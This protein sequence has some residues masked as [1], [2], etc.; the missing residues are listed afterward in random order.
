MKPFIL[1]AIM[2]SGVF[3][4]SPP[5]APVQLFDYTHPEHEVQ[6]EYIR[7][8]SMY[9]FKKSNWELNFDDD[10]CP[11]TSVLICPRGKTCE[12]PVDPPGPPNQCDLPSHLVDDDC[13]P[14]GDCHTQGN[15]P[16]PICEV[17]IHL[18]IIQDGVEI[19]EPDFCKI[20]ENKQDPKCK[21]VD[22]CDLL[23]YQNHLDECNEPPPPDKEYCEEYPHLCVVI[24]DVKG[25]Y[26]KCTNELCK[27]HPFLP[28]C[29]TIPP[30][31]PC[32]ADVIYS[33]DHKCCLSDN[34]E[35]VP[36]KCEWAYKV[37][38]S[39]MKTIGKPIFINH[40]YEDDNGNIFIDCI[41][42]IKVKYKNK[43]VFE[44]FKEGVDKPDG[45]K[46]VD[47]D[48]IEDVIDEFGEGY[49]HRDRDTSKEGKVIKVDYSESK[50]ENLNFEP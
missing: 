31:P 14:H 12:P 13:N 35:H 25:D 30:P 2:L 20:P 29:I 49:S 36:D 38:D 32:D 33:N 6:L 17:P 46:P 11:E 26:S 19:C 50:T 8:V 5:F 34:C 39:Y 18:R 3:L 16:I 7:S 28:H 42:Q 40:S 21:P 10:A 22:K 37:G 47:E 15:C 45:W 24:C 41:N 43:I 23:V 1:L 44:C 4:T 48:D 27:I 9:I